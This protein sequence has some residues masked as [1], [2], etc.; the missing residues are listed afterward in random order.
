M[1]LG[2]VIAYNLVAPF[3]RQAAELVNVKPRQ[4]SFSGVWLGGVLYDRT[5]S[6]D[7]VWWLGV[8]FGV[9]AAVVHWPRALPR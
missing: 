4:L 1:L 8:F 2:S 5:G 6:Y 7:M 9:M 3:R